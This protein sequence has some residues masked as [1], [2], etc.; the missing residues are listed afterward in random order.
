[1]L[2]SLRAVT[3]GDVVAVVLDVVVVALVVNPF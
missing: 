1:M 2:V 3:R